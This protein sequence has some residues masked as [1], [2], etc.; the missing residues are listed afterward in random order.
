L[1]LLVVTVHAPL[2]PAEAFAAAELRGLRRLGHRVIVVPLRPLR[3]VVHREFDE[4][5]DSVLVAPL[6]S[7]AILAAAFAESIRAPRAVAALFL[8]LA[9]SRSPRVLAKNLAVFPKALW[10]ARRAREERV[11]HIHA[12]WATTPASAGL[13]ASA[14]ARTAFSFTAHAADIDEDNLLRLKSTRATLLRVISEDGERR[15]LAVGVSR[16]VLRLVRLGVNGPEQPAPRPRVARRLAVLVPAALHAKKGHAYLLEAL[17]LLRSSSPAVDVHLELAGSGPLEEELRHRAR[18]LG[19]AD[20]VSF[21]GQLAHEDLLARYRDGSVDAVALGSATIGAR[22]AEGIPV[23]LIEA[24]AHAIPVVAADS[25]GVSE[26]VDGATGIL[27]G[28]RDADAIAEAFRRLAL[29]HELG[30]RLGAAGRARV[31]ASYDVRRTSAALADA[32]RL[33]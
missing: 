30:D 9:R 13:V 12:Y 5:A 16:D 11:D 22:L 33:R 4:A 24:M 14:V 29:D 25:G 20:R 26:L 19:V 21:L 15:L 17:H 1:N 23:S 3:Q 32:M 28:M 31:M 2:G 8:L 7:P 10:L 18:E 27:V 6:V